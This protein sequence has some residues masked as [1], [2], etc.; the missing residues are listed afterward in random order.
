M[1]S[2]FLKLRKG[3]RGGKEIGRSVCWFACFLTL[4]LFWSWF[5]GKKSRVRKSSS[6][7]FFMLFA[8]FL[9]ALR[10]VQK[11]RDRGKYFR[12]FSFPR[13]WVALESRGRPVL[14]P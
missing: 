14:S 6:W 12:I 10:R 9:L 13:R 3:I 11:R 5:R 1:T 2:D 8:E 7:E 4:V